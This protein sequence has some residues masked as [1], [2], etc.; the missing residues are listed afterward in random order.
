MVQATEDIGFS[1]PKEQRE[2]LEVLFW[3]SLPLWAAIKYSL[4]SVGDHIS[5]RVHLR[6]W[7]FTKSSYSGLGSKMAIF[8]NTI[9]SN[10]EGIFV[11]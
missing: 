11:L 5:S 10:M 8:A 3:A 1:S 2:K 4:W 6:L 7:V 9:M